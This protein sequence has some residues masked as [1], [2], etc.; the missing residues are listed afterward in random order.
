MRATATRPDASSAAPLLLALA[1][2]AGALLP[3]LPGEVEAQEEETDA[4]TALVG[5]VVSAE[6]GEPLEGV[7]V[8]L[9]G[10]EAAATTDA[11]GKFA[12]PD[13]SPGSVEVRFRRSEVASSVMTAQLDEGTTTDLT[14]RVPAEPAEVEELQ[15]QVDAERHTGI[16]AEAHRRTARSGGTLLGPD[17][18]ADAG[19]R[20]IADLLKEQARVSTERC[21]AGAGA[22]ADDGDDAAGTLG[23]GPDPD[24]GPGGS[25][26]G[27]RAGQPG[28][29]DYDDQSGFEDRYVPGCQ[30]VVIDRDCEP[31]FY[32]DGSPL[33]KGD[34]AVAQNL[35]D[36]SASTL[37][38]VEIYRSIA[39]MPARFRTQ[40]ACAVIA[41]WSRRG[42]GR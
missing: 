22:G 20:G 39:E 6:E 24:P 35:G 37:A 34:P 30:R 2:A 1:L 3:G 15:V 32:L 36:T 31:R 11:Q 4:E 38:A 18:L 27:G 23:D 14:A 9:V 21:P 28:G 7:E 29:R 16:V 40:D 17:E 26:P 25:D 5:T 33:P 13:V 42:G 8:T 19:S 10:E 41:L 12:F